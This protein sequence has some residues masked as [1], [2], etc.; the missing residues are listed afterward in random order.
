MPSETGLTHKNLAGFAGVRAAVAQ[1]LVP[2]PI[3]CA[4]AQTPGD[5]LSCGLRG[6][7]CTA[8]VYFYDKP[9]RIFSKLFAWEIT[10]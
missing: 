1:K 2:L 5:S 8:D 3:K 4:A 9:I 6:Q 7:K 10:S